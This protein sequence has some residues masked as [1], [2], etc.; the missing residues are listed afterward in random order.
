MSRGEHDRSRR[1]ALVGQAVVDVMGRQEPK[2][3][4]PVLGVVP[5]EEGVAVRAG[6]L[7]RAEARRERRAVFQRLELGLRERVVVGDV[8]ARMGLGHAQ[9]GQEQRHEFRGHGGPAVGVNRE[10][11][12]TDSL[13]AAR[14]ADEPLG[15]RGAL[16][17]GHHPADHVPSSMTYR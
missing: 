17:M 14:L 8:R 1:H 16:P 4:V 7:D 15:E 2:A 5:G 9:V 10:L 3:A 13:P 11:L 6:V 12:A